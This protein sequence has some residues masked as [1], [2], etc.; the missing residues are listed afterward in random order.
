MGLVI[1]PFPSPSHHVRP[2]SGH[3]FY[4]ILSLRSFLISSH[5]A[6]SNPYYRR[7]SSWLL[8]RL[9]PRKGRL[10]CHLIRSRQISSVSFSFL[11]VSSSLILLL[12]YHIGESLLP[13]VRPYFKFIDAESKLANYGF[14]RKVLPIWLHHSTSLNRSIKPAWIGDQIQSVQT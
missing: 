3:F 13:S 14:T 11:F 6:H 8:R 5:T 10:G 7:R 4:V 1:Y 2:S 12:S 9:S